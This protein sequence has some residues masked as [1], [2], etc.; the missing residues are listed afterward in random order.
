MFFSNLI[1]QP[2]PSLKIFILNLLK[3]KVHE[4]NP[5]ILSFFCEFPF[6]SC[7]YCILVVSWWHCFP[8]ALSSATCF[9][10]KHCSYQWAWRRDV[11]L[12]LYCRFCTIFSSSLKTPHCEY[13]AIRWY[14]SLLLSAAFLSKDPYGSLSSFWQCLLYLSQC[15]LP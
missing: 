15:F 6:H 13:D 9:S 4:Q 1:F 5:L 2:W 10:H 3:L 14:H 12:V 8:A 7:S 11:F